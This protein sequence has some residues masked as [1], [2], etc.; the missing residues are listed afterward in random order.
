VIPL[1]LIAF[2]VCAAA[3][4]AANPALDAARLDIVPGAL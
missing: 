1:A 3:L 2:S 4:A